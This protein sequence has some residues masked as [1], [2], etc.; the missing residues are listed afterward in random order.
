M[1]QSWYF[2]Y[3]SITGQNA[4]GI[5]R[6]KL[7]NA[8]IADIIGKDVDVREPYADGS[9]NVYGYAKM[10]SYI[11][12]MDDPYAAFIALAAIIILLCIVG[13]IVIIFTYSR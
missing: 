2:L 3:H 4:V 12:W 9:V 8:Q 1:W 7:G 13:I 5:I 10:K 11:W 6:D